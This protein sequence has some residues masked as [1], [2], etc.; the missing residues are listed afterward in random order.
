MGVG[1]GDH[2]IL[3]VDVKTLDPSVD[4]RTEGVGGVKA[5]LLRQLAAPC[6][7]KL[8]D[9]RQ[10]GLAVEGDL[11]VAG[12]IVGL[13]AHVAGTLYVVLTAQGVH[14]AAGTPQFAHHHRHV[15]HGHHAL[16]AGGMLGNAQTV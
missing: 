4:H 1:I 3:T 14:A 9:H 6:L 7:F 10:V 2:R 13:C 16:G 15:G 12:V 11:L 8:L 5:C